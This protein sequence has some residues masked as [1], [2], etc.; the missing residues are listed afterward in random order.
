MARARSI[1]DCEIWTGD[2]AICK[3]CLEI[4]DTT[5]GDRGSK[6]FESH[7]LSY[8]TGIPGLGPLSKKSIPRPKDRMRRLAE[9]AAVP[10]PGGH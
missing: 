1:L 3:F 2:T 10:D 6:N 8:C 5:G 9:I 4:L 7:L